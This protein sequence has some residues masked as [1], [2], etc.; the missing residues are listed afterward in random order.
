MGPHVTRAQELIERAQRRT[1]DD[2]PLG[3]AALEDFLVGLLG[4]VAESQDARLK[5]IH[6]DVAIAIL[7]EKVESVLQLI[8]SLG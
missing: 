8:S 3:G 5:L 2:A 7:V 6:V 4:L 1:S